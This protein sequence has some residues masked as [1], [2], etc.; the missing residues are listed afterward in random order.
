VLEVIRALWVPTIVVLHTVLT[1]PDRTL[2]GRRRQ[3]PRGPSR[4]RGEQGR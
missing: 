3:G 1:T 4:C 2:Q